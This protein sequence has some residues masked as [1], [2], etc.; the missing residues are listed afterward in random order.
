MTL[1]KRVRR[2]TAKG[3]CVCG[4]PIRLHFTNGWCVV[5]NCECARI[6]KKEPA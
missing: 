2:S 6:I 1:E 4:H 3:D 5:A